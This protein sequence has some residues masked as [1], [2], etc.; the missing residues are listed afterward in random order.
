M[1]Y[2]DHKRTTPDPIA[3][4]GLLKC[5]SWAG[6]GLA[7]SVAGGIPVFGALGEAEA[8]GKS[9]AFTF[10]QVSD[11]VALRH[12]GCSSSFPKMHRCARSYFQLRCERNR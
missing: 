12:S 2:P 3:R 7:W 4:R 6:A 9:A 1:T 8:A 11:C 10:V 5:M